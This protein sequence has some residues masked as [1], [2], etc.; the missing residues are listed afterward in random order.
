MNEAQKHSK[1]LRRI[2]EVLRD[3]GRFVTT[4]QR[5]ID[6]QK[7]LL[8]AADYIDTHALPSAPSAGEPV[9]QVTSYKELDQTAV[10]KLRPLLN[11][12]SP[13]NIGSTL[14]TAPQ[15][16]A[17]PDG[18]RLV[19]LR[20]AAYR[21]PRGAVYGGNATIQVTPLFEVLGELP[22]PQPAATS[23]DA[24]DAARYRWLFDD[25]AMQ[26]IVDAYEARRQPESTPRTDIF[27]M[28]IG[29]FVTKGQVDTAI[30]AAMKE[31]K[32]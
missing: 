22:A 16:A 19:K 25:S 2:V 11:G 26:A 12:K 3:C 18:Y 4:E 15:P 5:L 23:D 24:L 9:A 32:T 29:F 28:I 27:E 20:Q 30:D 14:Y 7:T 1:R 31:G 8:F 17:V 21:T 6:A 10:V 13:V